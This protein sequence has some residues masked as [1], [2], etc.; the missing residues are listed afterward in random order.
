M[1]DKVIARNGDIVEENL[2]LAPA[3]LDELYEEVVVVIHA[4]ASVRFD[5]PLQKALESNVQG[6]KNLLQLATK[7]KNLQVWWVK[8]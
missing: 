2:G 6:L 4:A 1:R 8:A 7:I 3:D 5:E